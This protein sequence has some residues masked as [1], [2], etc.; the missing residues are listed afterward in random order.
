MSQFLDLHCNLKLQI[1][2]IHC[3]PVS[4]Y[5]A[6]LQALEHCYAMCLKISVL[7]EAKVHFITT[8]MFEIN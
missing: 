2:L 3:T 1:Y 6:Q 4:V 5:K 8:F 7:V